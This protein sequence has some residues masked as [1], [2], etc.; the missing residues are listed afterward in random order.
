MKKPQV[1]LIGIGGYGAT[2]LNEFLDIKD[3]PFEFGGAADPFASSSPRFAELKERGIPVYKTPQDFFTAGGRADL[4][5]IAA[6]IHTHYS[7]ILECFKNK[8]H[9]L[10]EKPITGNPE[11]LNDLIAQEEKTGL[12]CAV[13][14]QYCFARDVLALKKDIMNNVYGKPLGL[15]AIELARRGDKYYSRNNWA[16]KLTAGGETILDSPLNNAC[17]HDLQLMLF[18]LGSEINR[19]AEA[20][21]VDAELWRARPDIENYDAAAIRVTTGT[22]ASINFYTAHCIDAEPSGAMGEFRFEKALIRWGEKPRSGFNA[23][24]ND[25]SVKSYGDL[26]DNNPVIKFFDCLQSLNTG[27]PPVCT[28]KTVKDHLKCVAMAQKFPVKKIAAEKLVYDKNLM[29]EN[30]LYY[31]QGLAEAFFRCYGENAL[32][33]ELG[34]E[35]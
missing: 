35:F 30:P 4:S 19:C 6:P 32:P 17:S 2:Y 12:F 9:V 23:Y 31:V 10:C 7:F 25:G 3:P 18:I 1:L 20:V 27:K 34:I 14:F 24:F 21:S 29:Q 5:V 15:K 33:S 8:S 11:R 16:G 28:L 26:H 22:G 13:G